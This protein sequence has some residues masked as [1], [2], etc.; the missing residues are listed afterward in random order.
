[1][2]FYPF[3]LPQCLLETD[4]VPWDDEYPVIIKQCIITPWDPS[5]LMECGLYKCAV[6]ISLFPDS[7]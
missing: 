1:M 5:C 6:P 7:T 3:S 4:D 2:L